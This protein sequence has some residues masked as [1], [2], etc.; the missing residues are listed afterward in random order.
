MMKY[1]PFMRKAS[2]AAMTP[3]L[4]RSA[5]VHRGTIDPLIEAFLFLR[6]LTDIEYRA[7]Q[8]IHTEPCDKL[9]QPARDWS[10]D[11]RRRAP[12]GPRLPAR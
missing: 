2:A 6:A 3:P 12:L 1:I 4:G 9:R 5:D 11:V 8:A 10:A 7:N